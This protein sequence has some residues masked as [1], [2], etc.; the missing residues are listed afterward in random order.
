[1]GIV[2]QDMKEEIKSYVF[3]VSRELT[4]FLAGGGSAI[5]EHAGLS[6]GRAPRWRLCLCS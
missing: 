2:G 3:L 1:V 4:A 5:D 6:E